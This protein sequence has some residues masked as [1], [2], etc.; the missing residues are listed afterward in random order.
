[1]SNYGLIPPSATDSWMM[2]FVS[3]MEAW[4]HAIVE[5]FPV[6]NDEIASIQRQATYGASFHLSM[7]SGS[8]T[9]GYI[10][11]LDSSVPVSDWRLGDGHFSFL[12]LLKAMVL[13][14][15]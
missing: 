9:A 14:P 15:F 4:D 11:G 8:F 12:E 7:K 2:H 5:N 13:R 1:M 6:R 3:W 10:L